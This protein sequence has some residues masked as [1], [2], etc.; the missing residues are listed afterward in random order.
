MY[1]EDVDWAFRAKKKGWRVCYYPMA[2]VVHRIGAASDQAAV[3]MIYHFHRSMFRFYLKNY[4]TGFQAL[5]TPVVL[6]GLVARAAFFMLLAQI[7]LSRQAQ[8]KGE[9]LV[10]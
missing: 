2:R 9:R 10:K 8:D 7:P 6:A 5:L 1:C 3:R 4:A